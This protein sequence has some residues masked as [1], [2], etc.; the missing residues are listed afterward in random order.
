MIDFETSRI[1]GRETTYV[2]LFHCQTS[3]DNTNSKNNLAACSDGVTQVDGIALATLERAPA[4]TAQFL[5]RAGER[6]VYFGV[7]RK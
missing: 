6:K 5:P 3:V 2:I 4:F 1:P 7:Q